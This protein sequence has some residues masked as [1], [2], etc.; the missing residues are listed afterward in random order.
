MP[1]EP[2][3]HHALL[4]ATEFGNTC[5]QVTTLGAFA[6]PANTTEDCLY[7]NVFTPGLKG[8]RPVIV[9]IHG[10]GNVT[11]ETNDYDGNKLA[12]GG[13]NGA[14]TVVV[15]LNYRMGLF[16]FLSQDD[17][18]AEGHL[19]GNYGILDIQAAL[20][21]VQD[22]IAAF[23]GDPSKVT[24]GGQSAGASDT[25][26]NLVSP[27]AEGL[28][29]R[30]IL[31]SSPTV[32]WVATAEGSAAT[33]LQRG[34]DFAA[35][36]DCSDAACLR[37]LSAERILQL[38]GTPNANGPYVTGPFVDGTII[39]MQAVVAWSTG[40]YHKM[41]IMGGATK[42]ES[43]FGESIRQYFA[44][45]FATLTEEEYT[46]RVN[47]TYAPPAYVEGAAEQV[48]AQYPPGSNP[49]ATYE[50]SFTDP[51][52]CR[53]LHVLELLAGSNEDHPV[54]GWDF[55]YENAP[56]Y[57][58]KM[59]NPENASGNFMAKASHTID[60]QFLFPTWHGGNL[61]VNLDQ[62]T[63]LP[64]ELEGDEIT[65]SDELVATWT[66]FAKTGDPNGSGAPEWP[67][68][69]ADSPSF[70]KQDI[71]NETRTEEQ[72]RDFYQ[73]DFWDPLFVYPTN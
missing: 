10:G 37:E 46:A 47:A 39:P 36:A 38:Q 18:N 52:K 2:P 5:P 11:G 1:P 57:F 28:F 63:G 71:P 17:L 20:R 24:L 26:A 27:Y 55:T 12:T 8:S 16:G 15:T 68:F 50:R 23:G 6:G 9:W 31:Q 69:T 48:L 59:P 30:A 45:G 49:Q 29:H 64:R 14:P 3:E 22:N 56:Y 53:T 21:W 65:L 41:P 43:T 58:P 4:D 72:Y 13:P 19:W 51:G 67:E 54:W 61:G 66:N 42:E 73:C 7:L 62:S 32:S 35:A 25:S 40:Q 60:I 44:P 34:N 70:L 33:A